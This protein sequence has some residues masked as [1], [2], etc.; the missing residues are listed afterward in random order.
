MGLV[1]IFGDVG[2]VETECFAQTTELNLALVFE[3]KAECLLCDLLMDGVEWDGK[4]G[5]WAAHLVDCL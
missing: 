2:E 4:S 1:C 3:T 5:W